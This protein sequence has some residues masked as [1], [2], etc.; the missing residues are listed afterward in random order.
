MKLTSKKLKM[1]KS[2]RK[3]L[4]F[5]R[6]KNTFVCLISRS[7]TA[8]ENLSHVNVVPKNS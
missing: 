7:K 3:H 4:I 5:R 1:K 6:R 8:R 2:V